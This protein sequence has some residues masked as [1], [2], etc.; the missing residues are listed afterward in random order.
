MY[1][2][3]TSPRYLNLI[4]QISILC[5]QNIVLNL[6]HHLVVIEVLRAWIITAIFHRVALLVVSFHEGLVSRQESGIVSLSRR[7]LEARGFKVVCVRHDD[8]TPKADVV[9]KT[10]QLIERLQK[11]LQ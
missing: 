9:A 4:T 5:Q 10:K 8:L 3:E 1:L 6:I 7:L 11:S 2:A